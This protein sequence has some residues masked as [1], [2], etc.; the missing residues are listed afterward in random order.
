[1]ANWKREEKKKRETSRPKSEKKDFRSMLH[2]EWYTLAGF[3]CKYKN[4]LIKIEKNV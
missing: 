1:M 4:H 2:K 3:H